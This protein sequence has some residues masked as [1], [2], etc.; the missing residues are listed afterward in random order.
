M[1]KKTKKDIN[2]NLL[3]DSEVSSGRDVQIGDKN[4]T[5]TN[6]YGVNWLFVVMVIALLILSVTFVYNY[7][8]QYND[9]DNKKDSIAKTDVTPPNPNK[10]I[11]IEEPKSVPKSKKITQNIEENL[12][13]AGQV[14]DEEGNPISNVDIIVIGL[15]NK[16][17]T[18]ENGWFGFSFK[19]LPSNKEYQINF[20]KDGFKSRRDTYYEIPKVNIIQYLESTN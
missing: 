5:I 9:D 1:A 4:T 16:I 14:L 13:I 11:E 8:Y 12:K 18:D 19:S 2:H 3:I 7:L 17:I 10:S 15:S 20:Q 6:N